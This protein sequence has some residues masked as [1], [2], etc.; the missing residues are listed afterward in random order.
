M[1]VE[2]PIAIDCD[3]ARPILEAIEKAGYRPGDDIAIGEL[4]ER[5]IT[6]VGR[7]VTIATA[8]ERIIANGADIIIAGGVETMSLVP[9][10]GF[11]ISP[12]LD[13]VERQPEIYMG[14]GLTAERVAEQVG[15]GARRRSSSSLSLIS[16]RSISSS[17]EGSSCAM[18][19]HRQLQC[20]AV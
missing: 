6:L 19:S 1:L 17:V 5:V 14:M 20:S 3:T 12:Y 2:K 7:P 4:A 15:F 9:M 8:A 13:S 18:A 11:R 10:T 16:A